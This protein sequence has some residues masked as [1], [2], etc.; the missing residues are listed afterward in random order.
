M[1]VA[2]LISQ[3]VKR[4]GIGLGVGHAEELFPLAGKTPRKDHQQHG[5]QRETMKQ[6]LATS[7]PKYDQL[8]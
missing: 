1:E 4:S 8:C 3:S 2:E 5:S 7:G 6:G